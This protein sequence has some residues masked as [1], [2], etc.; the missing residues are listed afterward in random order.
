MDD[1]RRLLFCLLESPL[2]TVFYFMSLK[3]PYVKETNTEFITAPRVT[4]YAWHSKIYANTIYFVK[5]TYDH[6][7]LA[8]SQDH[9]LATQKVVHG[10][11]P[12]VSTSFRGSLDTPNSWP[13]STCNVIICI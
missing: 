12:T 4:G 3:G 13:T 6:L 1:I 8:L 5:K 7:H 9:N 10:P 2:P 11:G